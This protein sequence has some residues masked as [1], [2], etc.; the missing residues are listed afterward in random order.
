[1]ARYHLI[2]SLN[3]IGDVW[4]I[5]RMYI[6]TVSVATKF[7][8]FPPDPPWKW[9]SS[10]DGQPDPPWKWCSSAD[11]QKLNIGGVGITAKI[12]QV[13]IDIGI[14]TTLE[15]DYMHQSGQSMHEYGENYI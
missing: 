8:V 11:G 9:C 3:R 7:A 13:C 4:A 2:L 6:W 12:H 15:I 5:T 1:M 10:A 14:M